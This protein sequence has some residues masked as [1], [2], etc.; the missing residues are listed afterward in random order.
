MSGNKEKDNKLVIG[1]IRI[2]FLTKEFVDEGM[3]EPAMDIMRLIESFYAL[4]LLHHLYCINDEYWHRV[5]P[6]DCVLDT[7]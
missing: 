7:E 5:I 2:L 6:V 4:E 1:F 3:I